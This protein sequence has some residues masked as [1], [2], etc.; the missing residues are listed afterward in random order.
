MTLG[1]SLRIGLDA[2]QAQ[3]LRSFL[4]MLGII[5]G[6]AAVIAMTSISSGARRELLETIQKL[7]VN[8]IIVKTIEPD[9]AD[10]KKEN[11]RTNPD[12]LNLEDVRSIRNLL[13]EAGNVVPFRRVE[14][15]VTLPEDR[16]S[17]LVGTW[18]EFL[19]V[20]NVDIS[21]GR[22]LTK[23]DEANK[24]TVAVLSEALKR[25]LFPLTDPIGEKVKVDRIWFTVVGVVE[26]P[27]GGFSGAGLNM[28]NMQR[29]MFV[30]LATL[31]AY[32]SVEKGEEPLSAVLVQSATPDRVRADAAAVE[33]ILA[34]R[35]RG[36]KDV[37]IVVPVELLKQSQQ[38]QRIFNIVMGAIASI[39]LLVGGIGIMNIMLSSV[40]ERT[41]EIG[42][43][44]AMGATRQD[45][46]MQFLLEAVLLS[47][48][49]GAI[50]ILLG[51][52]MSW[53]ISAY[54]GWRTA[55]G[56]G[57]VLLA[58]G[59]S[60]TVGIGFGWWPARKAAD[61]DVINALRYE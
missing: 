55:V 24:A 45:V 38:T 21:A 32:Y 6:V 9:D 59:V 50:G 51:F 52:G 14:K 49:G 31:D 54:A 48:I 15:N 7:G 23:S 17:A 53:S 20:L 18:P 16:K 60:A 42:V 36:A 22:F 34:R 26:P 44:R 41:R 47:I 25:E 3:K 30:P 11:L 27:M 61:M 46:V 33:R 4:T 39:S 29:D 1:E 57:A 58:F 40:L 8:N 35:H 12:W 2:L 37:E 28:P 43:R 19:N 56:P 13:P 5:F 10:Q